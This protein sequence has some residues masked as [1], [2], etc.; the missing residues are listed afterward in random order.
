MPRFPVGTCEKNPQ[1]MKKCDP[2]EED[3][4]PVMYIMGE[5]SEKEPFIYVKDRIIGSLRRG[6]IMKFKQQSRKDL[7]HNKHGGH[8]AQSESKGKP[9]SKRIHFTR[10]EMQD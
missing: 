1:H 8:P 10:M 4:T 3:G 7:D 5:L 9:Q 6:D 2:Q